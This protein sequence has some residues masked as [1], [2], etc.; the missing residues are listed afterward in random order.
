MSLRFLVVFLGIARLSLADPGVDAAGLLLSEGKYAEAAE[1][2]GAL[3]SESEKDPH[4]SQASPG[5]LLIYQG[6]ALRL[7]GRPGEAEASLRKALKALTETPADA[8]AAAQSLANTLLQLDR[9]A[10]AWTL[11]QQ[12]VDQTSDPPARSQIRLDWARA[13]ISAGAP[14]AAGIQ[15]KAAKEGASGDALIAVLQ[16]E[17]QI[18]QSTGSYAR[19]ARCYREALALAK[20]DSPDAG[21]LFI[22]LTTAL[23]RLDDRAGAIAAAARARHI[24]GTASLPGHPLEKLDETLAGG[25]LEWRR[26]AEALPLLESRITSL[27]ERAGPD[28]AELINP[29]NSLGSAQHLTGAL[30][31]ASTSLEHAARLAARSL[32]I[33]HPLRRRIALNRWCLAVDAGKLPEASAFSDEAASSSAAL[34]PAV[35]AMPTENERSKFRTLVDEISPAFYRAESDP[36]KC[37]RALDLL[38]NTQGSL[39]E[40]QLRA[41]RKAPVT[42]PVKWQ[43]LSAQLPHGTALVTYSLFREYTGEGEFEPR[44]AAAVI[45]PDRPPVFHRLEF[46]ADVSRYSDSLLRAAAPLWKGEEAR[47]PQTMERD[48]TKLGQMLWQPLLPSLPAQA[49]TVFICLDGPLHALPFPALMTGKP[50]RALI[51]QDTVLVFLSTPQAIRH[52][53]AKPGVISGE[54]W[55]AIDA[56]SFWKGVT[57]TDTDSWPLNILADAGRDPLPGA[58]REVA[59]LSSA[60]KGARIVGGP[61]GT[62]AAFI[63]AVETGATVCHFAGHGVMRQTEFLAPDFTEQPPE[64]FDSALL[65]PGTTAAEQCLFAAELARLNLSKTSLLS[66]A[67]C[68]SGAGRS[69]EREGTYNLAR[70]AHVAGVRDVLVSLWPLH[71][72]AS[73]SFFARFYSDITSGADP[74]S[75]AWSAQK[76]LWESAMQDAGLSAA[77]VRAAPFRLIRSR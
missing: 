2:F 61:S 36:G 4:K 63:A 65:F 53:A 30:T 76:M 16:T 64:F 1:A 58:A 66:L 5:R 26:A 62:R 6:E 33:S 9:N 35:L 22:D 69:Q 77:L 18:A 29:L 10:E 3:I 40:A 39:L 67:S 19:A 60:G 54:G 34:L 45:T 46:A 25:F 13:A 11:Y 37:Q 28:S 71:D 42:P 75:A 32:P 70:A 57:T 47:T 74:A 43:D 7:A 31:L 55:L 51:E 41:I 17:G 24:L 38:L 8:A 52:G 73:A 44:F 48:L 72:A 12:A 50:A 56:G 59:L 68:Y 23:I 21:I 27:K 15:F 20:S 14:E 49:K